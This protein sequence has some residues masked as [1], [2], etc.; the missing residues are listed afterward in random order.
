MYSG[1][2]IAEKRDIPALCELWTA[3]FG[4]TY[5][6]V[7]YFYRE[8]FDCISVPVYTVAGEPVSMINL[9]DAFFA[10]RS[11]EYPVKYVYAAGTLPGFRKNGIMRSLLFH[12]MENAKQNGYG[13]FLKPVQ[14]LTDYYA[15]LGFETDNHLHFCSFEREPS[16]NCTVT[17]SDI[18]AKEYNRLRNAA[19]SKAPYVKWPDAHVEWCAAENSFCGGRMIS[20]TIDGEKHILMGYPDN[21]V[22]R[23]A[24]TDLSYSLLRR[25][26][27]D[28]CSL[29][30]TSRIAAYMPDAV[31]GESEPV[32][33]SVV[34][35][36]P[37]RHSYANLLLF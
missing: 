30:G 33:S 22:L 26:S 27:G 37:L 14:G 23:I 31:C 5:E 13:L 17:F 4:D 34:Y 3:C 8:N 16:E 15:S 32:I 25:I 19:F 10:D 29:Y 1:I 24:E 7:S 9:I 35:N 20:V 21:G 12:A 11:N 36:A 6:Y 2:R 28:L 18:S